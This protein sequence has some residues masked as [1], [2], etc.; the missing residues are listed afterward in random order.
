[1]GLLIP[2]FI[3]ALTLALFSWTLYRNRSVLFAVFINTLLGVVVVKVLVTMRASA[4]IGAFFICYFLIATLTLF[5]NFTVK[6][7]LNK[8]G[9]V[10]HER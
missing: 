9:K 6:W 8:I 1:M 4:I 2:G 3:V 7:G 10:S 5:M